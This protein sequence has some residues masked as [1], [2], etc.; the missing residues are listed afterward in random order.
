MH[1]YS[2]I[3]YDQLDESNQRI[4]TN[5]KNVTTILFITKY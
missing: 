1:N 4:I 3:Y 2:R 5:F